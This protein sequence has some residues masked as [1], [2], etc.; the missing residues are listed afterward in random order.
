MANARLDL[1]LD[2]GELAAGLIGGF[3]LGGD[4]LDALA[5]LALRH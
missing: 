4:L 1:I 3:E 2:E 5:G